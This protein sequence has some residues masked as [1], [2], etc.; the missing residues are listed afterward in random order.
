M[1]RGVD[2]ERLL[3]DRGKNEA[4]GGVLCRFSTAFPS[5]IDLSFPFDPAV[6]FKTNVIRRLQ[7][8]VVVQSEPLRHF[9]SFPRVTRSATLSLSDDRRESIG[10]LF[11]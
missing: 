6:P 11:Q 10:M 3:R 4:K 9:L 8:R 5:L 2:R 7:S 1:K